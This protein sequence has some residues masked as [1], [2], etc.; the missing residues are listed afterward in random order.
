MIGAAVRGCWPERRARPGLADWNL[1]TLP[2]F[3]LGSQRHIWA[4][5]RRTPAVVTRPL[6]R[7]AGPR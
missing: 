5:Q 6:S 2:L 7:L 3:T 4:S 1:R